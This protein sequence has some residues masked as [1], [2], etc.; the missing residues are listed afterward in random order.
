[1]GV[2]IFLSAVSDEFKSYREVL[3]RGLDRPSVTVKIQE[4]LWAS[5]T[6]TLEKLHEYVQHCDAVIHLVGDATGGFAR[7]ANVEALS[8]GY[9]KLSRI[10]ELKP[11][12]TPGDSLLSY[13]QW[14]AW[15]A[16][17]HD[18][19]LFIAT[20]TED[21]DREEGFSRTEEQQENQRKHLDLLRRQARH[22]EIKFRDSRELLQRLLSSKL[23]D[24]IERAEKKRVPSEMPRVPMHFSGR[25][26]ELIRL[27]SILLDPDHHQGPYEDSSQAVVRHVVLQGLG[28]IGKSSLAAMYA[29]KQ[30]K[31]FDEVVWCNAEDLDTLLPDLV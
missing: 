16:I 6:T 21:A 15:L 24:I 13:T 28:G 11:Y 9:S 31:A 5:G 20:P 12:L 3:R 26:D 1:L 10:D 19:P 22:A 27:H 2:Q 25:T 30:V 29:T 7:F 23:M 4:D 18:K 8:R 17:A 14:E